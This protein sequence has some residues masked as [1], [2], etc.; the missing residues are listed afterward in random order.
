MEHTSDQ[1]WLVRKDASIHSISD[2]RNRPQARQWGLETV[3][4]GVDSVTQYIPFHT[5][6]VKDL[7]EKGVWNGKQ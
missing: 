4:R 1:H 5:G 3:F 6:A 2:Y 7:K